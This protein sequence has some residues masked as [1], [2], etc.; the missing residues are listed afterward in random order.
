M[1]E[2]DGRDALARNELELRVPRTGLPTLAMP[3]LDDVQAA[4][5]EAIRPNTLRAYRRALAEFETFCRA[6]GVPFAPPVEPELVALYVYALATTRRYTSKQRAARAGQTPEY[7]AALRRDNDARAAAGQRLREVDL[8]RPAGNVPSRSMLDQHI[9]A[10]SWWHRL[11]DLPS[12][13]ATSRVRL[14]LKGVLQGNPRAPPQKKRAALPDMIAKMVEAARNQDNPGQAVRDPA[15]LLLQFSHGLRRSEVAELQYP[16]GLNL[17]SDPPTVTLGRTKTIGAGRVLPLLSQVVVDALA[18]WLAHRTRLGGPLFLPVD[19]SGGC[20]WTTREDGETKALTDHSVNRII[21]R[22]AKLAGFDPKEFAGHSPRRGFATHG[23]RAG[24]D[25]VLIQKSL[26]HK[27]AD[28]TRGYREEGLL[29]D[30][31][32]WAAHKSA[33]DALGLE[34]P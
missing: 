17:A 4:R 27:K 30:A 10:I 18:A 11:A 24:V 5:R 20:I 33:L 9:G 12:P 7:L 26:G 32:E 8:D 29:G 15:L 34:Q 13:T 2:P 28:T 6:A 21:K 16:S 22:L 1:R 23:Y 3:D 14:V 19:R 25:E 31:E